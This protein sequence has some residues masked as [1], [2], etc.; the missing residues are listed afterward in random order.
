MTAAQTAL[1][2]TYR[3][4]AARC[5]AMAEGAHRPGTLVRRAEAFDATAAEIERSTKS[6]T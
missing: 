3:D 2:Q 4:L 5:R 6:P 1:A